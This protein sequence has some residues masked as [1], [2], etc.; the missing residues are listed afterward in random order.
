MKKIIICP[1]C[2]RKLADGDTK[3]DYIRK[4]RCERCMAWIWFNA[5]TGYS[6]EHEIP[7]RQSCSGKVFY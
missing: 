3:D 6:K 7:P 4:V 2:H 5:S 1:K